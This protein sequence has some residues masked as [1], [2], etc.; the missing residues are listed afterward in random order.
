MPDIHE[1]QIPRL[2][3]APSV[4]VKAA[5]IRRRV[6]ASE[7]TA[8]GIQ[9]RSA[10]TYKDAPVLLETA[11]ALAERYCVFVFDN[12]PIPRRPHDRFIAIDDQPTSV[13]LALASTLDALIAPDSSILHLAG[14][15]RV[16]CL[17]LF[18]PTDGQVRSVMYSTV[19]PFDLR[20]RFPCMPCWRHQ[21]TPCRYSD[22]FES[23]CMQQLS[24]IDIVR[25]LDRLLRDAAA[26]KVVL[27]RRPGSNLE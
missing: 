4:E 9:L 15:N 2:R 17:G 22:S 11:R 18:G 6:P 24:V 7:M 23:S 13:V 21:M 14:I 25:A 3:F 1:T 12:R 8:I 19:T 26:S 20:D 27:E 10:E 16:P 5:D